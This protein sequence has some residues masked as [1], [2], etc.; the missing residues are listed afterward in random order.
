MRISD[1]SSDVCSSDLIPI[2]WRAWRMKSNYLWL[3][4]VAWAMPIAFAG[5]RLANSFDLVAW[6]FWIDNS[7]IASMAIEAMLSSV[8]IAY[9]I[10]LLSRARDTAIRQDVAARALADPDPL[11]GLLNRRAF[12]RAAIGRAGPQPHPG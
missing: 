2:M 6:H 8:A 11:T 12:L 4:A 9:R 5:A 3:F 10:R 1:W 7:T